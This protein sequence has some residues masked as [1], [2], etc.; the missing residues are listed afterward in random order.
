MAVGDG[1][2]HTVTVALCELPAV[3]Q[4]FID[5]RNPGDGDRPLR[6]NPSPSGCCRRPSGSRPKQTLLSHRCVT[7]T[8]PIADRKLPLPLSLSWLYAS[9]IVLCSHITQ[10]YRPLVRI[11][12]RRTDTPARLL[13]IRKYK[14]PKYVVL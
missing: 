6:P 12:E 3:N 13:Q 5:N 10:R 14:M 11:D 8:G 7:A 2:W 1:L 4:P 9:I